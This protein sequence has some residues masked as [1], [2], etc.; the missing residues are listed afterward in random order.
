MYSE[1]SLITESTLA[2]DGSGSGGKYA[3]DGVGVVFLANSASATLISLIRSSAQM[4]DSHHLLSF[5]NNYGMVAG[6][7][8][9]C[10]TSLEH[11]RLGSWKPQWDSS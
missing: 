10:H 3:S 4:P 7:V 1:R 9:I 11:M 6:L 2:V 8:T 5:D